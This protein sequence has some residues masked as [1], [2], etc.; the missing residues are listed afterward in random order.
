MGFRSV[1]AKDLVNH[2]MDRYGKI[3]A[4]DLKACRQA[5]VEPIE[6]YHP[7]Y[8]CLQWVEDAIKF[9]QDGKMPFKC[10]QIVQMAYHAV[11]KTGIYYFALKEWR[12]KSMADN[13]WASF[14]LF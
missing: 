1:S 14:K 7:I 6:L 12:K 13:T 5:L 10:A 4:S 2:L 9:L 3:R 8:V 11:N